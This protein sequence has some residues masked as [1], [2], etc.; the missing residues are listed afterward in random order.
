M[1]TAAA[2]APAERQWFI[3][4]RWQE[5]EG[6]QRA[7]L[8]RIGA[9]GAFY[10]V[11]LLHFYVFSS[12]DAVQQHFHQQATAIAVAWTLVALAVMLCLRR[13]IFPA[14]LKFASTACDVLLLTA[15]A[16]LGGGPGSAMVYAYF[17]IIALAALRFSLPFVWFATLAAM[18]G[19]WG[20]VGL[21][22]AKTS[23]WFDDKHAVPPV[24]QL[25]TLLSLGL[26]GIIIGQVVRAV[27]GM[28]AEYAER[29]EAVRGKA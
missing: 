29:L 20:L 22:D 19:Y 24:V 3:V 12:R 2:E 16:S 17:L 8:L 21:E 6:E 1:A 4:A 23:R 14:A 18:L 15:L 7:N 9:I 28:A 13:Q 27:K 11:Q 5:Y 26:T 25:L 10:I